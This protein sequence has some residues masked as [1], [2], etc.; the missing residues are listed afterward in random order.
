MLTIL[1]RALLIIHFCINPFTDTVIINMS[2]QDNYCT[3]QMN[4]YL[5]HSF[6]LIYYI[7]M[8]ILCNL[9]QLRSTM[10]C[11]DLCGDQYNVLIPLLRT[12]LLSYHGWPSI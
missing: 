1:L 11:V 9:Q 10:T 2:K 12:V 7:C 4:K 8:F 6:V 5:K 3:Y